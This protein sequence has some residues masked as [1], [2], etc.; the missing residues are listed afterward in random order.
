MKKLYTL[1][2][3]FLAV[4][5]LASCSPAKEAVQTIYGEMNFPGVK[6]MMTPEEV[7]QTIGKNESDFQRAE[8]GALGDTWYEVYYT[9]D[10]L[11]FGKAAEVQFVFCPSADRKE[12]RLWAASVT[13]KEASEDAF[14]Y[15]CGELDN[16]WKRQGVT[17]KTESGLK[18]ILSTGSGSETFEEI[19]SDADPYEIS[20]AIGFEESYSARSAVSTTDLPEELLQK[21]KAEAESLYKE[22]GAETKIQDIP[23]AQLSSVRAVYTERKNTGEST[24]QIH[25][26][27]N[28][29]CSILTYTE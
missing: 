22:N 7:F 29:L 16:E 13:M 17:A 4:C 23:T 25:F 10:G 11:F 9:A 19:R 21:Y 14:R 24:L 27:G 8:N 28:G 26:S 6:W 18:R 12:L 2:A 3:L 1:A 20:D 15:V 5:L